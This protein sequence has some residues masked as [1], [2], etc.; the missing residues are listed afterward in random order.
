M[1]FYIEILIIY[2]ILDQKLENLDPNACLPTYFTTTLTCIYNENFLN[3]HRFKNSYDC[4]D[5]RKLIK[6]CQ[7][8]S[9][10][11]VKEWDRFYF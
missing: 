10:V 11:T 9:G 8:D 4:R 1:N 3:C 5:L 6:N 7:Y 2:N